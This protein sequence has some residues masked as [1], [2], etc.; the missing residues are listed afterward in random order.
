MEYRVPFFRRLTATKELR[1]NPKEDA[2]ATL[3]GPMATR[4]DDGRDAG[5]SLHTWLDRLAPLAWAAPVSALGWTRNV[6][7]RIKYSDAR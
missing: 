4:C 6:S 1:E 5:A 3:C 2:D 7:I